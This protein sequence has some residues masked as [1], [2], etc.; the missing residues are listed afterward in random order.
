MP[1]CTMPDLKKQNY[2]HTTEFGWPFLATT[3]RLLHKPQNLE[4]QNTQTCTS[5][6]Y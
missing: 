1:L 2:F 4:S 3:F 5:S 6:I